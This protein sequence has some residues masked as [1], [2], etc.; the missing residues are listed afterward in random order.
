MHTHTLTVTHRYYLTNSHL[1]LSSN[2]VIV[3]FS[4][5]QLGIVTLDHAGGWDILSLVG[6]GCTLTL[7]RE[8][9]ILRNSPVC[10]ENITLFCHDY[11]AN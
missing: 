6:S 4:Y 8:G 5:R 9:V 7:V 10:G 1:S 2:N 11:E 3:Q